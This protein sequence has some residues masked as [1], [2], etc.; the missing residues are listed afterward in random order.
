M[1]SESTAPG[2]LARASS[3]P[4]R[5]SSRHASTRSRP[6]SA[7][8]RPGRAAPRLIDRRLP[9]TETQHFILWS[10]VHVLIA[11]GFVAS[12]SLAFVHAG[13]VVV[14][15]VMYCLRSP[16]AEAP[17]VLAG[18]VACAEVLWRMT[19]G[20]PV[21]EYSKYATIL[22]LLVAATRLQKR[23]TPTAT[24][25]AVFF[26]LLL[27]SVPLTLSYLDNLG[28]IRRALSFYLAGPACL[29]V[30][31]AVFA[32][33]RPRD[34][35]L[36]RATQW[37]AFPIIG[38]ASIALRSTAT[39]NDLVFI[40]ESNLITSGYYGPNQ[41]SGV[42]GFGALILMLTSLTATSFRFRIAT[43]LA[44]LWLTSQAV[45]TLSRGGVLSAATALFVFI[46]H[47]LPNRRARIS[48]VVAG[49]LFA[50]LLVWVIV[51][52]INS[53]TRGTLEERYTDWDTSGRTVV[54][55]ADLDLWSE[56][57]L[58]GVGPGMSPRLRGARAGTAAH[59]EFTRL[60]AEHGLFGAGAILIMIAMAVRAYL[61]APSAL[62]R[63]F[64]AACTVWAVS[65]M[66]H[67][68]MRLAA[69]AFA[70]GLGMIGADRLPSSAR[71]PRRQS[72]AHRPLDVAADSG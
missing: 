33:V 51:P 18:Y 58:F 71:S 5:A 68:A 55:M 57:F 56:N 30:A 10:A 49:L 39:A 12:P 24:A 23:R 54:A 53:F 62:A 7:R 60:L 14:L 61:R 44:A 21:W 40:K 64:A 37:M 46:V 29:A 11:Q 27:P 15:G 69:T 4:A 6:A 59:T 67:S 50:G 9:L 52:A 35:R 34:L 47:T 48:F 32:R 31:A 25:A 1:R 26:A 41:V 42:L 43:T 72:A 36:H 2:G 13:A 19:G 28:A 65:E 16:D 66:G 20:A 22:L 8:G 17:L 63:G 3:R 45:L 70:F 38:I